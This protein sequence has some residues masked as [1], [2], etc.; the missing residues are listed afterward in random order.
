M[1]FLGIFEFIGYLFTNVVFAPLHF[2]RH[3]DGWWIPNIINIFFVLT[4]FVLFGWWMGQAFKFKREG[5]EDL[6]K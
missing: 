3:I 4:G 5:T 6:P 2:L 1:V